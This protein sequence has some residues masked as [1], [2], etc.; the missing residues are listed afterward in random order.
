MTVFSLKFYEEG[1]VREG[2]GQNRCFHENRKNR[3][4]EKKIDAHQ[5]IF[6]STWNFFLSSKKF[7]LSE[8]CSCSMRLC[9]LVVRLSAFCAYRHFVVYNSPSYTCPS[10]S[11]CIDA[12]RKCYSRSTRIN[13]PLYGV[14]RLCACYCGCVRGRNVMHCCSMLSVFLLPAQRCQHQQKF[15]AV[16]QHIPAPQMRR[17]LHV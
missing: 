10:T 13:L 14:V 2:G 8:A 7:F 12:L 1:G 9:A 4:L 5:K 3:G 15:P 17:H 6:S 16:Q 11:T